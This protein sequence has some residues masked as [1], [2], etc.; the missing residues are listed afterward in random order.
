MRKS[1]YIAGLI[2]AFTT[3][4]TLFRAQAE[5]NDILPKDAEVEKVG[6]GF[7]FVEGPAW[8]PGEEALY[9]TDIPRN[10]IIRFKD[11]EFSIVTSE[12]RGANGLMF[13]KTGALVMCEGGGRQMTRAKKAGGER[14]VLASTYEGKPLNSPNDL[15]L[16]AA[17][18]MYFTDPRYGNRDSMEM[19]IEG[20]YYISNDK[21]LKR[22]IADLVRPNGIALSPNGETLYV[23]DNGAGTLFA[24]PVN[25]PGV[26]GE[27]KKLA[28][29]PGP[30][31]MTVD[32]NGRLYIT[33]SDGVRVVSPAGELL[34]TISVPEQPANCAF[35][36]KDQDI[37]YI[38]ARKSLYRIPTK[39]RGWHI[40]RDGT[41]RP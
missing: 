24:Y 17:G 28:D 12:S 34:G 29:V 41:P 23:L 15:W 7:A 26:L 33:A 25:Q 1:I 4:A 2:I 38:T 35:G 16:D 11:G 36:G 30:D 27:G 22:L 18:G 40:H 14:E 19:D 6:D 3:I 31:G 37:L 5:L 9:F 8:H 20:V 32:R 21:K 10:Q 13:D 39:T